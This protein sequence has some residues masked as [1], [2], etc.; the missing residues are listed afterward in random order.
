MSFLKTPFK[1]GNLEL[2]SNV[3]YSPLAGCSDY[4]YRKIVRECSPDLGLF[5]CEMV[6]MD[7]LVR[8][9]RGTFNLLDYDTSQA[10]IGAQLIGSCPKLA[11]KGAKILEDMG[12]CLIDLNCGCPVDKVT[13]DGCGSGLLKEPER[14]GE[15]LSAMIASVDIPITVKIRRGWDDQS[16][17]AVEITKIAERAGAKVISVHGRTRQQG[18]KGNAC[19]QIIKECKQAA[20]TIKV[21]GNGDVFDPES[22]KRLFEETGCDAVLASRGTMGNPYLGQQIIEFLGTGS[23]KNYDLVDAFQRHVDYILSYRNRK[24]A[25]L[26]FRRVG[27]WYTKNIVGAKEWKKAVSQ[28]RSLDEMKEVLKGLKKDL[29]ERI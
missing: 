2:K 5:F 18:Y 10:P 29:G 16:I 15:I 4:P 28:V 1:I 24:K 23:Y 6:K 22:A 17:N 11:A 9:D 20:N 3:L 7:A 12:F 19:W 8:L 21:I 27:C 25:M 14:I 13:G 26:D